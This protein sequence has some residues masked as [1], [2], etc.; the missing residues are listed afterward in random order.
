M[1]RTFF[2]N[3]SLVCSA[4]VYPEGHYLL[5]ITAP[6]HVFVQTKQQPGASKQSY[7]NSEVIAE[8]E[9]LGNINL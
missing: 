3:N 2:F 6:T 1:Y 7:L 4:L 5:N 9:L 8:Y